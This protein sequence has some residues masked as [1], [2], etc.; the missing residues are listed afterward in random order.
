MIKNRESACLSRKRKKEVG[1]TF[2]SGSVTT[3]CVHTP[4]VCGHLPY[5]LTWILSVLL[6]NSLLCLSW[7]Q[8]SV[9]DVCERVIFVCSYCGKDE[10]FHTL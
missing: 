2:T 6:L 4:Y 3:V 10:Y 1:F 9:E 8:S 5:F 7:R